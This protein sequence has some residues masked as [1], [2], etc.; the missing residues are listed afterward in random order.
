MDVKTIHSADI[1]EIFKERKKKVDRWHKRLIYLIGLFGGI[2]FSMPFYLWM[3]DNYG[4]SWTIVLITVGIALGFSVLFFFTWIIIEN[5]VQP[6]SIEN[7][8]A[9]KKLAE[10]QSKRQTHFEYRVEAYMNYGKGL[11]EEFCET[12]MFFEKNK[13]HV[14]F[15]HFGKIRS[16]DMLYTKINSIF[17]RGDILVIN[18]TGIGSRSY[19]IKNNASEL[20]EYI[21]KK[22][23]NDKSRHS[24]L[25]ELFLLNKDIADTTYIEFQYCKSS[26]PAEHLER[27]LEFWEKDS[28]LVHMDN[29]QALYDNYSKFLKSP[30]LSVANGSFDQNG[31]YYY[32]KERAQEILEQINEEKPMDYD[33]FASWLIKAASNHNG[34][35]VSGL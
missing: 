12:L 8:R 1:Q 24:D 10:Y 33:I 23:I 27:G 16:F 26:D 15:Y 28:L 4:F 3:F 14:A 20:R 5:F 19:S 21:A 31:I 7:P 22:R 30:N 29:E 18:G 6:F 25:G 9:Q 2:L 17:I 32:S 35:Y 13:L 34:F 11:K